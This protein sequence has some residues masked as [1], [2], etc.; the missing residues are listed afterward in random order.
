MTV[1]IEHISFKKSLPPQLIVLTVIAKYNNLTISQLYSLIK[2]FRCDE[3]SFDRITVKELIDDLN[4]LH[5][6]GL[7]KEFNGVYT[8][9]EKGRVLIEKIRQSNKCLSHI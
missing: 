1:E 8:L 7:V 2:H 9:T 3:I 6:L 4:I 5:V